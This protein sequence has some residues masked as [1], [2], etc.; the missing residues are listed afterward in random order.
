MDQHWF[1]FIQYGFYALMS[2]VGTYGVTILNSMRRSIDTLNT[3]VATIIE[4]NRWYEK[5]LVR[6]EDRIKQCESQD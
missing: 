1:E 3:Q 4:K 5:E 2:V 6:L